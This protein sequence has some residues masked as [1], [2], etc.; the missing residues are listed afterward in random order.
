MIGWAAPTI[1]IAMAKIPKLFQQFTY[2]PTYSFFK[3]LFDYEVE[4]LENLKGL[5]DRGVIFASNH[6]GFFD[7]PI[8]AAAMPRE[9]V[10][11]GS[12]FPVRFVVAKEY[13]H[14]LGSPIPFPVSA[15]TASYVRVNGSVPVVR[16][17]GNLR[18]SLSEAVKVLERGG[19][20]WIYPEGR[21]TKDGILQPGKKGV[22]HL[23]LETGAPIVPV[24]LIGTFKLHSFKTLLER[25]P[26]R[27]R[28]GEPIH[29]LGSVDLEEGIK[30]VMAE[31]GR[32]VG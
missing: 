2:W 21:F 11:P 18:Q 26:I 16:A 3:V 32:L 5:E 27:I 12:F 29:S 1:Y 31:I 20:I 8:C 4:G 15:L 28:I 19:K 17:H 6:A 22:A 9:G 10:V 24:G 14:P 7:G 23:H 25:K 13:F 30:R